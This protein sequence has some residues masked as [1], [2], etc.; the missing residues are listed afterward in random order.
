MT[1]DSIDLDSIG[2]DAINIIDQE[3]GRKNKNNSKGVADNGNTK[4]LG[5]I[6]K[7]TQQQQFSSTVINGSLKTTR[8]K[9]AVNTSTNKLPSHQT[10]TA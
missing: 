1:R 3:S 9:K 6:D 10:S 4:N 5:K 7:K 2:P 8:G